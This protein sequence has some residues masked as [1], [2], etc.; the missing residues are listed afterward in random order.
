MHHECSSSIIHIDIS[1]A[2]ILLDSDYEAHISDFGTSKLLKLDSSNWTQIA[3]TYGYILAYTMAETEKCDVYSFGV[4]ALEVIMGKH[5]RELITSLPTLS[6]DYLLP[7]N[8]GDSRMLPPTT[9]VEKLVKSVLILS[10]AC[11]NSNPQERPTMWQVSN[12]LA[13]DDELWIDI[14]G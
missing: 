5:P 7:A 8:V 10:R 1:G 14:S 3:G 6:V 11:L 2:N 13:M 12:I 4:V 9:Q